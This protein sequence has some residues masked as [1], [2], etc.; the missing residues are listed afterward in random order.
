M[1]TALT[2]TPFRDLQVI[3]GRA[4]ITVGLYNFCQARACAFGVRV[5]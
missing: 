1:T 4:R 2:A 3:A 5:Y